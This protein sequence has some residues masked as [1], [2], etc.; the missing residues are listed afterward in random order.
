MLPEAPEL[1]A[2]TIGAECIPGM[3]LNFG[4]GSPITGY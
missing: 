4:K 1:D 2:H 3:I